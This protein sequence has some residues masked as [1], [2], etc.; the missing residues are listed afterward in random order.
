MSNKLIAHVKK[1]PDNSWACP[2][3][4][5]S[6]LKGTSEIAAEFAKK[7]NSENFGRS[8]GLLHDTGKSTESWQSYLKNRSGF[9]EEAHI[10]GKTGKP[11]HSS[12]S[13]N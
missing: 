12:P 6:H 4:L 3:W 2:H 11:D 1:N 9:D 13:A 5:V 7:F 8:G 10:E